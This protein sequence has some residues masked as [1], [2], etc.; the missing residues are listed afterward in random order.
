MTCRA[1]PILS[2]GP[3]IVSTGMEISSQGNE[4]ESGKSQGTSLIL[5]KIFS[6]PLVIREMLIETTVAVSLRTSWNGYNFKEVKVK[7]SHFLIAIEQVPNRK[8]IK[9]GR[10]YL[11]SQFSG[12]VHHGGEGVVVRNSGV[13]LA[14]IWTH[15]EA[16][17]WGCSHISGF[18]LGFRM[19]LYLMGWCY[20]R[21]GCRASSLLH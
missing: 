10:V 2:K 12:T 17:T 3:V 21:S 15:Q 6:S 4:E 19:G 8:Q 11:G 1:K 14:H 18:L 20:S 16:E 13:L 5:K 9:G 7:I